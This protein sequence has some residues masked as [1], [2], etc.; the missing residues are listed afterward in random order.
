MTQD[1]QLVRMRMD[2]MEAKTSLTGFKDEATTLVRGVRTGF[3]SVSKVR[4]G[5]KK[6]NKVLKGLKMSHA[7]QVEVMKNQLNACISEKIKTQNEYEAWGGA[8]R[9]SHGRRWA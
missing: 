3:D 5:S 1:R 2:Y 6:A 9:A 4:I 7:S 8:L